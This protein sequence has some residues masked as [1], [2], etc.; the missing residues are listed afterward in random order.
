MKTLMFLFEPLNM[1]LKINVGVESEPVQDG[2]GE[3]V[4]DVVSRI[5]LVSVD[6]PAFMRTRGDY[7]EQAI[8]EQFHGVSVRD[9]PTV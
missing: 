6:Q 8:N 4:D 2:D 5:N 7:I 3:V 9:L 1:D